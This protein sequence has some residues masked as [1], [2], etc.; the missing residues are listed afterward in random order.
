MME[1][2]LELGERCV[3]GE[4]VVLGKEGKGPDTGLAHLFTPGP[5][6]HAFLKLCQKWD[7]PNLEGPQ[8]LSPPLARDFF[9]AYNSQHSRGPGA[10]LVLTI[11]FCK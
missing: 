1:S 4:G 7:T 6:T 2:V 8:Q 5:T 10:T 3:N 9:Q 11:G